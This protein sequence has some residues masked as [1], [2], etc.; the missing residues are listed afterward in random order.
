[1][2]KKNI[3]DEKMWIPDK[4]FIYN[5]AGKVISKTIWHAENIK[6]REIK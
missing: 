2:N 6:N 3:M 1:M 4:N 5:N